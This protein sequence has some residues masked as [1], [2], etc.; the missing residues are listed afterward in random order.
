[1]NRGNLALPAGGGIICIMTKPQVDSAGLRTFFRIAER[2]SLTCEE[3]SILLGGP[4]RATLLRWRK[5][6]GSSTVGSDAIVRLSYV[7]GI[8]KALHVLF[9]DD[10]QADA[11]LR[12]PND[13]PLFAGTA[14][15]D[16]MLR[17]QVS[18]LQVVRNY[19]DGVVG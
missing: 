5:E 17:G 9:A 6:P 11:W 18:D 12:R 19:L 8:Y 13:A 16:R 2:W 15:L 4:S 14:A 7:I 1:M 3:Q 10:A